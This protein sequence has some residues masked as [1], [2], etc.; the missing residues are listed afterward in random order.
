[1]TPQQYADA[2]QCQLKIV[3]AGLSLAKKARKLTLSAG[4]ELAEAGLCGLNVLAGDA[5]SQ[6]LEE[7]DVELYQ[8][9]VDKIAG[10]VLNAKNAK[11]RKE[12][13][14]HVAKA[15]HDKKRLSS[16]LRERFINRPDG[17][18]VAQIGT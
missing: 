6:G 13:S 9:Q 3:S 8:A 2:A 16:A 12:I 15:K 7:R 10:H 14:A 1:M 17:D 4:L 11:K 5:I 18:V